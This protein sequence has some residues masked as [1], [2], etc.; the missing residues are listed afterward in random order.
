M[1]S[2]EKMDIDDLE[3][4]REKI[5]EQKVKLTADFIAAGKVLDAKRQDKKLAEDYALLEVKRKALQEKMGV[6]P[7]PQTVGLK[8]LFMKGKQ[9]KIGG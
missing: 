4:F 8:A 9:G 6:E 5:A 3:R 2:F 1:P 7:K